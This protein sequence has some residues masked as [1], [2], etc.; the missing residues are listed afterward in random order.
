MSGACDLLV[1]QQVGLAMWRSL[2]DEGSIWQEFICDYG[3]AMEMGGLCAAR[4]GA[5][6][7]F[8]SAVDGQL[9]LLVVVWEST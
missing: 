6:W 1:Q 8:V 3:A 4:L 9:M 2:F 7:V 5:D